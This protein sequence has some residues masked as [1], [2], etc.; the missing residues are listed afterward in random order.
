MKNRL[1]SKIQTI[2][3]KFRRSEFRS[4]A[5]AIFV[6]VLLFVFVTACKKESHAEHETFTC[7][8]HPTV[9]SDKPGTCP[10]CGMDLVRKTRPGEDVAI[11]G[12]LS[13]LTRSTNEVVRASVKTIKGEFKKFPVVVNAQGIVTYDTRNVQAIA[14][15]VAGRLEK[16]YVRY[17]YQSVTKG[18]KI[19]SIY[20]PELAGAQRELLFLLKNDPENNVLI[21]QSKNKLALLGMNDSQ[22]K[23]LVKNNNGTGTVAIYSTH[24]GY[25]LPEG[26]SGQPDDNESAPNTAVVDGAMENSKASQNTSAG[27]FLREGSYVAAGQVLFAIAGTRSLRIEIDLSQARAGTIS[28]RDSIELDF[29]NGVKHNGIVDLVQP[30]F[31]EGQDF[32]KIR[33]YSPGSKD[34]HIGH[35]VNANISLAEKESLW[36]PREAVFDLGSR[37]IV[38]VKDK[39]EFRPKQ[40]S[41]GE[42][43]NNWIEIKKG[44]SSA[45][46]IAADAHFLVDSES[47]VKVK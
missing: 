36:V 22:V 3:P 24:D 35:L 12:D 47:A 21:T 10:V 16:L 5:Q 17:A 41:T 40:V 18:Q 43:V 32:V 39:G 31:S 46:N 42:M 28:E 15:R 13:M 34:L 23:E 45:D 19:A 6:M 20:S 37:R 1:K 33:V 7:P 11:T 27:E 4:G 44:L 8:M 25:V 2:D 38:F 26:S 14:S 30:F 9:I 29:G